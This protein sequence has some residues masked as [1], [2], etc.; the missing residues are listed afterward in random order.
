MLPRRIT[1]DDI[2]RGPDTGRGPNPE[3]WT[4]TREK[5][6]GFSPGFTA[7]DANGTVY[8]IR[9]V[10]YRARTRGK[11]RTNAAFAGYRITAGAVAIKGWKPTLHGAKESAQRFANRV[12][13]ASVKV[14]TARARGKRALDLDVEQIEIARPVIVGRLLDLD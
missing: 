4:L 2:V 10:Y 1:V 9:Q 6:G 12:R 5:S 14:A 3:R 11:Y 13:N 7:K 8:V